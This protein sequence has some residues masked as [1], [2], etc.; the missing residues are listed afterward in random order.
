MIKRAMLMGGGFCSAE[1][2]FFGN[3]I[4]AKREEESDEE[5][6][7]GSGNVEPINI[8][9]NNINNRVDELP[10]RVLNFIPKNCNKPNKFNK[11]DDHDSEE[12]KDDNVLNNIIALQNIDGRWSFSNNKY[13]KEITIVRNYI[14]GKYKKKL[15]EITKYCSNAKVNKDMLDDIA[16]TLLIIMLINKD[17]ADKKD[18]LK[19]I[20][21]KA[22][23]FLS[24]NGVNFDEVS[25][26]I[27]F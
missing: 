7:I 5:G 22:K 19:F 4:Q 16:V 1:R 27:R 15:N 25:K 18:E 2:K 10:T 17:F 26:K 20:E 11:R 14:N 21:S 8:N 23:K 13:N 6:D 9:M 3:K 12:E 24:K